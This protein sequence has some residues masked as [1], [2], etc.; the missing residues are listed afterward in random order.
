[1]SYL[2]L[3]RQPIEKEGEEVMLAPRMDHG[4]LKTLIAKQHFE[5]LPRYKLHIVLAQR[6]DEV[7]QYSH[8]HK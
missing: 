2:V 4:Q 6:D 1:M 3:L 5:K 8:S 7:K